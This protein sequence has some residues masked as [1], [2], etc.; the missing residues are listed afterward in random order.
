MN[1]QKKNVITFFLFVGIALMIFYSVAIDKTA[2]I[3]P[4]TQ[5]Q[6]VTQG[7]SLLQIVDVWYEM[8]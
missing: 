8:G 2:E 5:S 3:N 1:F 7:H 6:I 4:L